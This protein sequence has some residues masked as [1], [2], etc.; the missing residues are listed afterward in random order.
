MEAVSRSHLELNRKDQ[1]TVSLQPFHC[2]FGI[3]ERMPLSPCQDAI[4]YTA[5][6]PTIPTRHSG[7]IK[8]LVHYFKVPN[9]SPVCINRLRESESASHKLWVYIQ[10]RVKNWKHR[11]FW[12]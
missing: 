10:T 7:F 3:V 4:C 1:L 12:L 8:K 6:E 5:R 9:L 2:S 11:V